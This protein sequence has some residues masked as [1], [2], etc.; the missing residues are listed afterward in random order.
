MA[1]LGFLHESMKFRACSSRPMRGTAAQ[2]F[3]AG[4]DD[5][6]AD[7][8]TPQAGGAAKTRPAVLNP[9]SRINIMRRVV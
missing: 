1:V 6:R 9:C 3:K 7:G 2:T 5:V 4:F 8:V